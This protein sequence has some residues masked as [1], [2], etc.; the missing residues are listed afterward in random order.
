MD[1]TSIKRVMFTCQKT[2]PSMPGRAAAIITTNTVDR[3][4]EIVD[5]DGLDLTN[6]M[7]IGAVL[8]GHQYD[9]I[10]SIP[11]GRPF[12]LELLHEGES[13]SLKAEW[14]WQEDDVT[15]L[16]TAVHKSWDRGF[17]RTVSIGFIPQE[18]AQDADH[19]TCIKAELL[20]FSICAVPANPQAMR[21]NG[22]TDD[23]V[24][25]MQNVIAKEGRVLSK[26]NRSLVQSCVD[27]LTALLEASDKSPSGDGQ[28]EGKAWLEEL[29]KQL[30]N[31][32]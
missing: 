31:Q 28:D 9:G 20:E 30:T 5:P 3:Q 23:E 18:W 24:K 10:E 14:D 15:P 21:L 11:V 12:A 16:I 2:E 32:T 26:A 22:L 13:K 8:Y 7:R 1:N 27:S 19:P 6:F 25:A 29:H 17:L 4:G